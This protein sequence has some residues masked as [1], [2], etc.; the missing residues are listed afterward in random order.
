MSNTAASAPSTLTIVLFSAILGFLGF[1]APH[2][3]VQKLQLKANDLFGI[4]VGV[5]TIFYV[6]GFT[7]FVLRKIHGKINFRKLFVASWMSV[8]TMAVLVL[9]YYTATFMWLENKPMPEGFAGALI[10]KYNAFGMI[11]SS[12]LALIFKKE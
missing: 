9:I 4:I 2:L 3:V 1:V 8:L 12:L 7:I 6:C 5:L 11:F 10:L